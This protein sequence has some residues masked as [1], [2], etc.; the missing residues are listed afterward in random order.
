[1]AQERTIEDA[2]RSIGKIHNELED[3]Y[4]HIDTLNKDITKLKEQLYVAL[5]ADDW[6]E[7]ENQIKQLKKEEE[8]YE[9]EN[10][11]SKIV[12]NNNS[13]AIKALEKDSYK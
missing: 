1:M 13:K 12:K 5:D 8:M 10:L 9:T 6:V 3:S 2:K 4:T 7:L 11:A